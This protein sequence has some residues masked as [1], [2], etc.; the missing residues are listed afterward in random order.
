ML[1]GTVM[2]T[3]AVIPVITVRLQENRGVRSLAARRS[4]VY[5]IRCSARSADGKSA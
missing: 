2:S 1:P 4:S 5:Q 3:A